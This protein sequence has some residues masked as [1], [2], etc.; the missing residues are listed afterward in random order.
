[1]K[2]DIRQ[3]SRN[4]LVQLVCFG[5]HLSKA[6]TVKFHYGLQHRRCKQ[7]QG[8]RRRAFRRSAT[9]FTTMVQAAPSCQA[10][11]LHYFSGHVL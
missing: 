4:H 3:T 11:L 10:Q 1:M 7:E 9:S 5:F 2:I 8:G 6:N